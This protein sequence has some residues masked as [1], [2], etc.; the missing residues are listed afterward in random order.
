M[1]NRKVGSFVLS[2]V[3]LM[4]AAPMA[5]AQTPSRGGRPATT[6]RVATPVRPAQAAQPATPTARPATA[7]TGVQRFELRPSGI[8]RIAFTSDAPLETIDGVSTTTTG[9]FSVDVSNPSRGLTGTVQI[10]VNTLR[11]GNDMRDEHLRGDNWFDAAHN[12]N[13]SLEIQSTDI[14]VAL[15]PGAAV[16]GHLRARL[17]MHGVTRDVNVPVTA[18]LVPLSNEHQG[19]QQFGI[20]ADML[21]VQSEFRVNLSDYNISLMAPLRL[22]V[23]NEIQIRVNVTAFRVTQ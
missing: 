21:R 5:F 17:T 16:T 8:S 9:T 10:P 23:S 3:A 19:M 1:K 14:A 22:K 18:R 2:L 11:T 7:I 12:P 6:T 15:T 20:N 4:V 13:I